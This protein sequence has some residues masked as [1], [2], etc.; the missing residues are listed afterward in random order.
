KGKFYIGDALDWS[1]LDFRARQQKMESV[2]KETLKE[3][4]GTKIDANGSLIAFPLEG[5]EILL[6][7]SA[8]PGSF[9]IPE[10]R[11][12]VSQRFLLDH[13][14][15]A[16]LGSRRSGPIHLIACQRTL[17]ESQALRQLGFPDATIVSAPFG[18]YVADDVSKVQ[19]V[20][21]TNCRD[22]TTTTYQVQ[23]VFD[24]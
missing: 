12:G 24:W 21:L 13:E 9:T 2:L 11:E 17:T 22:R 5:Q 23:R 8:I 6:V 10:A 14:Y 15:F 16:E 3:R 18:V 20:F 19:L 1:R 7:C 4:G